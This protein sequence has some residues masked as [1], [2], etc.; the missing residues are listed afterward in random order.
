MEHQKRK[1]NPP[2]CRLWDPERSRAKWNPEGRWP[3]QVTKGSWDNGL[4]ASPRETAGLMPAQAAQASRSR[5]P[6]CE[7]SLALPFPS[8][9]QEARQKGS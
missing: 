4:H 1:R 2:K 9:C 3:G 7:P 6:A 5:G 8:P